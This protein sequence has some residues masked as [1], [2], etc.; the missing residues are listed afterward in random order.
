MAV[1]FV[2]QGPQNTRPLKIS[3]KTNKYTD[4]MSQKATPKDIKFAKSKYISQIIY[5]YQ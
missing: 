5:V 3:L 1:F 2:V 4:G